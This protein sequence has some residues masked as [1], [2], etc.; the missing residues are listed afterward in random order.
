MSD[1][2]NTIQYSVKELLADQN[3]KLSSIENKLDSKL[4]TIGVSL[5]AKADNQTL[6][7]IAQ[8]VSILEQQQSAREVMLRTLEEHLKKQ[9]VE[10]EKTRQAL[11]DL[12]GKELVDI[13]QES[14]ISKN[15]QLKRYRF[16]LVVTMLSTSLLEI[17]R[18]LKIIH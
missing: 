5:E 9:D 11:Q 16:G 18:S 4:H 2:S 10:Y 1:P 8:R 12:E 17:L 3:L 15:N 7:E 14:W 6:Q 13:A